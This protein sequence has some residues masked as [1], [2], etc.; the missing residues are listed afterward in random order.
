[1]KYDAVG[2]RYAFAFPRVLPRVDVSWAFSPGE[3]V[4]ET[5]AESIFNNETLKKLFLFDCF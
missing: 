1:M 2:V 5:L 3:E 4:I